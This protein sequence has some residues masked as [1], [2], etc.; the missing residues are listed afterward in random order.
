MSS[1]LPYKGRMNVQ[2]SEQIRNEPHQKWVV[3]QN[4]QCWS[5]VCAVCLIGT[6]F[7]RVYRPTG[8]FA[9]DATCNWA[10]WKVSQSEMTAMG[11]ELLCFTEYSSSSSSVSLCLIKLL[12][13][14]AY[15]GQNPFN[16]SWCDT[17]SVL[18]R[19]PPVVLI[20][21]REAKRK[22]HF[23]MN[24][25]FLLWSWSMFVKY[26]T[27]SLRVSPSFRFDKLLSTL[28]RNVLIGIENDIIKRKRIQPT[29][30]VNGHKQLSMSASWKIMTQWV[31]VSNCE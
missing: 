1:F 11:G 27:R 30:G 17:D 22:K 25:V 16:R 2:M 20:W 4:S 21:K 8:A 15:S 12:M 3:D 14:L 9:E 19:F 28:G 29:C 7:I 24:V 6:R 18:S 31:L 5:N 26:Y 23:R 13:H 10:Q